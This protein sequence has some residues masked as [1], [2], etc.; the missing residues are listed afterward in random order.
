LKTREFNWKA[1]D[2]IELWGKYWAPDSGIKAVIA[3]VH[4]M[5]E[6]INRY[7][8][9]AAD[10]V[11]AGFALI[12]FDQ[13]G[14]GKSQGQRGHSPNYELLMQSIDDL[15]HKAGEFF[16]E[17]PVFLMGHSMGGQL[18]LNYCLDRQPLVKGVIASSPFLKLAFEPPAWKVKLGKMVLNIFPSLP[19]STA[20]ETAAISQLPDEVK[21]YENDKLVHDR[22][23]P[24]MY[25]A[26][27]E[28]ADYAL[29]HAGEF[30]QPLL[31]YHGTADRLT[32][33]KGT[34][35]FATKVSGDITLKLFDGGYHETHHDVNRNE[36]ISLLIN[37][38]NSKL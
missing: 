32:S 25:F 29:Q 17:I 6:H 18:V 28:K 12:G 24:A 26:L 35:E 7:E 20:L 23:T 13:R 31:M 30:R 10:L 15:L 22:I 4:G 21:K 37:W 38:L 2:G 5:G 34:S 33:Y 8:P 11:N 14:H 27:M 9:L 3:L 36:L 16:P 1:A 19:Q